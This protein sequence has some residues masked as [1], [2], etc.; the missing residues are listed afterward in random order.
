M[1][2]PARKAMKQY[3]D[4]WAS[5]KT[6]SGTAFEMMLLETS[7]YDYTKKLSDL[8]VKEMLSL[9]PD[10]QGVDLLE[11]GA[12]V[13][14]FTG[15]LATRAKTVLSTDFMQKFVDDN[16]AVNGPKHPNLSFAQ[17]DASNLPYDQESFHFIFTNWL[18]MYLDDTEVERFAQQAL[19]ILRCGGHLFMRES[20]FHSASKTVRSDNPT[21][22]RSMKA[23][24]N[25]FSGMV[26]TDTVSGRSYCFDFVFSGNC[27]TYVL[28]KGNPCQVY[29][30][31]KKRE[32]GDWN[33]PRTV[34]IQTLLDTSVYSDDCLS[35]YAKVIGDG[36]VT[37]GGLG[38]TKRLLSKMTFTPQTRVLDV[39][40]GLG[41]TMAYLVKELNMDVTGLE[42]SPAAA[43]CTV[44]RLEGLG[45]NKGHIHVGDLLQTNFPQGCFDIIYVRETLGYLSNQ[46]VAFEK[47]RTWIKPG[48]HLLLGDY[49]LGSSQLTDPLASFIEGEG[50]QP[51]K[52]ATW[53]QMLQTAGFTSEQTYDTSQESIADLKDALHKLQHEDFH[54]TVKAQFTTTWHNLIGALETQ[55]LSSVVIV[56]TNN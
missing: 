29:W 18:L 39:G 4:K 38:A 34:D 42:L 33:P 16:M 9:L 19:K 24:H 53:T 35:V 47:F 44:L 41:G 37:P 43:E 52:V 27:Q 11:L 3:W 40:C 2:T 20:C 56:A 48:G 50:L 30:M 14:R 32:I 25:L 21:F 10:L 5:F 23:Y 26:Y 22:Y 12:G 55:Q 45:V 6:E 49:C 31:W 1:A 36:F 15:E 54:E 28:V 46:Q 7:G 17:L 51:V 8:D 13:G